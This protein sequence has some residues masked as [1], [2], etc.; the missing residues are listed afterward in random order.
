M[1]RFIILATALALAVAALAAQQPPP[2]QTAPTAQ[3]LPTLTALPDDLASHVKSISETML[4]DKPQATRLINLSARLVPKTTL[5]GE[6]R[7]YGALLAARGHQYQAGLDLATAYLNEPG[8]KNR[9]IALAAAI[10]GASWLDKQYTVARQHYVT[11]VKEYGT[12][13]TIDPLR[14]KAPLRLAVEESMA[15]VEYL[16][17]ENQAEAAEHYQ[18]A[19]KAIAAAGEASVPLEDRFRL[20]WWYADAVNS[21]GRLDASLEYLV[22]TR[23]LVKGHQLMELQLEDFIL[24]RTTDKLANQHKYAEARAMLERRL[25]EFEPAPVNKRR[26]TK[27]LD[28]MKLVDSPAPE[29]APGARWVGAEPMTIAAL[30]GKVVM[31]EFFTSG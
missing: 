1:R 6:N 31:L 22:A 4:K 2:P 25:P 12:R 9:Q 15:R 11:Y 21:S 19:L 14:G 30:R 28:R 29:L 10:E 13:T 7:V 26:I 18:I 24:F 16:D 23:P 27:L 8:G 20:R 5:T 17:G 3:A